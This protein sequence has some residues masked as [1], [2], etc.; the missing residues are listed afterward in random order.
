MAI[1]YLLSF[2]KFLPERMGYKLLI[3][4][5]ISIPWDLD[6]KY[7]PNRSHF[8][9]SF[10]IYISI[11]SYRIRF[12]TITKYNSYMYFATTSNAIDHL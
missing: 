2:F 4:I 5:G 9:L 11:K 10:G 8:A 12:I 7:I 6:D 1:P 3:N